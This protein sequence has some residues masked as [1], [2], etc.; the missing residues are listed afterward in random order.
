[1]GEPIFTSRISP[2]CSVSY[3]VT[4]IAA[5]VLWGGG[6][7]GSW[8]GTAQNLITSAI[9]KIFSASESVLISNFRLSAN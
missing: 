6:V 3:K 2:L 1:M 4:S 7:F 5:P 9:S 8:L